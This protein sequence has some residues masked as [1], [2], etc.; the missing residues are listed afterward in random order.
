MKGLKI[1]PAG[2]LSCATTPLHGIKG[3]GWQRGQV[4]EGIVLNE[5]AVG[6]Y[7]VMVEGKEIVVRS[8]YKLFQGQKIVMEVEGHDGNQ[9]LVRLLQAATKNEELTYLA[10]RMGLEDTPQMKNLLAGFMAKQLPLHQ[11]LLQRAVLMLQSIGGSSPEEV[12]LILQAL[13]SYRQAVPAAVL[14]ALHSFVAGEQETLRGIESKLLPFTRQLAAVLSDVPGQQQKISELQ[15]L[16]KEM[17]TLMI[18]RPSEGT[19]RLLPQLQS[20]LKAQLPAAGRPEGQPGSE[21]FRGGDKAGSE[22]EL[23]GRARAFSSL[24]QGFGR[25]LQELQQLLETAGPQG[26][27]LISGGDILLNQLAGHQLFQSLEQ[28][29]WL[30]FNLPFIES[31]D[32]GAWGQLLIKKDSGGSNII[33]PRSFTMTL[34]L[35][36]VNLGQL[37]LEIKVRGQVVQASGKAQEER[38]A[39]ILKQAWPQLQQ[40]FTRLGYQ[41]QQCRWQVGK[42]GKL[43]P[44]AAEHYQIGTVQRS[45]LDSL[46]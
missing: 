34:L 17:Q 33:N 9:Y 35:N 39:E 44:V 16:L 43:Q 15:Q 19:A 38:V 10:A 8:P 11:E 46:V 3:L 25:L 42:V 32:S 23:Q 12:E 27:R 24:L 2:T 45:H 14:E 30:F 29:E 7:L 21:G 41:L 5:I 22:P 20:L 37:L 4:L 6:N 13:K 31:E 40:A 28:G 1:L 18:L 36:T 26:Q